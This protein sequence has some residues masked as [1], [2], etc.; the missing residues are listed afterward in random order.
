M[1]TFSHTPLTP[2]PL[3]GV[4][5]TIPTPSSRGPGKH[6]LVQKDPAWRRALRNLAIVDK[7]VV[8]EKPEAR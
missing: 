2:T 1:T 3:H 7:P 5:V 6:R 4:R 8:G